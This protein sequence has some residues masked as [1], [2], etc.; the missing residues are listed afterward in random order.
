MSVTQLRRAAVATTGGGYEEK[1]SNSIGHGIYVMS[2]VY[3]FLRTEYKSLRQRLQS[4]SDWLASSD[5]CAAA[6]AAVAAVWSDWPSV[7][8]L[9]RPDRPPG[10]SPVAECLTIIIFFK[11]ERDMQGKTAGRRR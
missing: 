9:V 5:A 4:S 1:P 10:R 3:S 8:P 7:R 11:D 6:A 2:G